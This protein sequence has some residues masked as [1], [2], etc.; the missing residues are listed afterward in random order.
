MKAIYIIIINHLIRRYYLKYNLLK[1]KN[2]KREQSNKISIIIPFYNDGNRIL[3]IINTLFD[4][5]LKG[6]IILVDDGS[7]DDSISI[8][9]NFILNNKYNDIIIKLY[10]YSHKGMWHAFKIGLNKSK[11]QCIVMI[12]NNI[13]FNINNLDHMIKLY[14][15]TGNT[16]IAKRKNVPI[17]KIY[18]FLNLVFFSYY[19]KEPNSSVRIF[20][21]SLINNMNDFTNEFT[22]YFLLNKHMVEF[23]KI[24]YVNT[25]YKKRTFKRKT[26]FFTKLVLLAYLKQFVNPLYYLKKKISK[27][28]VKTYFKIK[29]KRIQS[30]NNSNFKNINHIS[31]ILDGNRRYS[32]KNKM[33]SKYQHLVGLNKAF[34]LIEYF[35]GRVKI[36][37]LY[38]F[39]TNNWK[40]KANEINNIMKLITVLLKKYKKQAEGNILSNVKINFIITHEILDETVKKNI[41]SIKMISNSIKN[42]VLVIDLYFSY[43]GRE[44]IINAFDKYK[45]LSKNY[46]GNVTL[47]EKKKLLDKIIMNDNPPPDIMLRTGGNIRLSDFMLYQSAYTELFFVKKYLP[48]LNIRDIENIVNEFHERKRNY[49]K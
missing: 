17:K 34:E 24:I 1:K 41:N 38:V 3:K 10:H 36:L 39:A 19:I 44:E 2:I 7:K 16:I 5:K 28:I 26:F 25:K 21:K 33:L 9:T 47:S 22:M 48:E 45:L 20:N 11:Y 29:I 46:D 18:S 14:N 13:E 12:N 6:E 37:S 8:I 31:I 23:S 49:G 4:F 35:K 32:I 30:L 15:E 42:P 43:S 40:R 27:I